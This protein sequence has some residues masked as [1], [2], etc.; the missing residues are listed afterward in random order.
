MP[1]GIKDKVVLLGMGCSQFGEHWDKNAD[2]LIV[3]AATECFADAGVDRDQIDAAWFATA[4][5]EGHVGKS[6]VPL[7]VALRLPFIPVTRVENACASGTEALRGAVY[8]VASGAADIALAV[9]VEKLKDAGYGGLPQRTRGAF[10][11]L[12]FA[13]ASAPGSFAQLATAYAAKHDVEMD[14]LKRAMAQISV[15]SHANATKNPKAH[16][17]N[18]ITI[19][20]VLKAPMVAEPLGLFD[21]C[22]VSDGA[23]AAIVTTPEIARSLGKS[24]RVAIK[25]MQLAVSNGTEAGYN[26]WDGSYFATTRRAAERA[27]AEAEIDKPREA[28][29]MAEVHDCFSITELV[30]MEDLFLSDEG[31]AWRDFLDGRYDADGAL[32]CQI[33]GGLKCFGH[34]IGASGLRMIYEM[35]LQLLGRAGDRQLDDPR[36]GMT[37]NLGGWPHLNVASISILGRL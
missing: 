4:I 21:C 7:S 9:G 3:E 19:D 5:E 29:D 35:Y 25:A 24:D 12:Y 22:G 34:P 8:A 31:T 37:H 32:P 13:N 26:A 33:D 15:K 14:D 10:N 18:E 36:V 16:L 30:T 11:D 17:R 27:Y 6:A 1:Q 2:D 23:A 28:V 20:K